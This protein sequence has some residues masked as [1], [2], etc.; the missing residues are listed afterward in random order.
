MCA[1]C[2]IILDEESKE[3]S[4]G[5]TLQKGLNT[6]VQRIMENPGKFDPDGKFTPEIQ[7][8]LSAIDAEYIDAKIATGRDLEAGLNRLYWKRLRAV[9]KEMAGIESFSALL[10]D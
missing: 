1:P 10:E 3:L 5:G 6:A 2:K 7:N 9:L 4:T 8:K